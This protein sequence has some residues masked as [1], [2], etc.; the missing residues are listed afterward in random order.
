M[1]DPLSQELKD[2]M[3]TSIPLGRW[4]RMRSRR[5]DYF[6]G[7]RRGWI[8][9]GASPRRE[10][11]HVYGVSGAG[12]RRGAEQTSNED[13]RA[14]QR[15]RGRFL[16]LRLLALESEPTGF[17]ESLRSTL[18]QGVESFAQRIAQG[19]AEYDFW[20]VQ[21][22]GDCG[23]AFPPRATR[24]AAPHWKYLGEFSFTRSAAAGAPDARGFRGAGARAARRPGGENPA[25]GLR[26]SAGGA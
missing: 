3:M 16:D 15:R 11:R 25:D 20:R 21:R 19:G 18:Q 4:G 12:A 13:S 6:F 8:Y 26:N 5:R 17:G 14:D 2:A 9:Y 10:R 7:E 24:E 1:T 23:T 22:S